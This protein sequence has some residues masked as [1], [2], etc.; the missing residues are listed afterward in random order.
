M[1]GGD[2]ITKADP[3]INRMCK[4]IFPSA[5]L[6]RGTLVASPAAKVINSSTSHDAV[7]T[8]SITQ[9]RSDRA[10]A[11]TMVSRFP[12]QRAAIMDWPAPWRCTLL[13]KQR[14]PSG[15]HLGNM[16]HF[17]RDRLKRI[18]HPCG[19][20]CSHLKQS[21]LKKPNNPFSPIKAAISTGRRCGAAVNLITE[22]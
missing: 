11:S 6:R 1:R 9:G 8:T 18:T 15:S 21:R 20:R 5:A 2:D 3:S 17:D 22:C 14:Q 12:S 4:P 7:F 13:G 10:I 19:R 16:H